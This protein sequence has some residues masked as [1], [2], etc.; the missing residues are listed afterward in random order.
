MICIATKVKLLFE[1][2]VFSAVPT[3]TVTISPSGP[4]QNAAVG[5]DLVINCIVGTVVGV[6]FRSVMISWMGPRED[7]I[8][9]NS[10]VTIT[11]TTSSGDTYTSSLQITYLLEENVGN[12]TCN[13][14]IL[15]TLGSQSVELGLL[16]CKLAIKLH[17]HII[18]LDDYSRCIDFS[19]NAAFRYS[20]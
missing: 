12:Y 10:R 15:E 8:M 20:S 9:N 2:V 18:V 13:V 16:T 1:L 6:E 4:I 14:M 3:P 17:I 19:G 7:L 11:P 5:S